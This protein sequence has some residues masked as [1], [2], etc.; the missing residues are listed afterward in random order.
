MDAR[1]FRPEPMNLARQLGVDARSGEGTVV[2]LQAHAKRRVKS[3]MS[4]STRRE[5]HAVANA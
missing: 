2:L 1:I 3:K 4:E 5:S